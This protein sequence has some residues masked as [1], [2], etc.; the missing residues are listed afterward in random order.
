MPMHS[1]R[2]PGGIWS[3]ATLR[4][5]RVCI[6]APWPPTAPTRLP[7][8]CCAI[9]PSHLNLYPDVRR[10][11]TALGLAA[12]AAA[13]AASGPVKHQGQDTESWAVLERRILA[14]EVAQDQEFFLR[15]ELCHYRFVGW[16]GEQLSKQQ[17]V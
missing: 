6:T 15:L 12:V 1:R 7:S 5:R 13:P 14:A 9:C 4:W 11:L 16:Y 2:W 3:R 10:I 8:R 17:D